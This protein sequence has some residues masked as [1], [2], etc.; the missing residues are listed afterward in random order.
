MNMNDL[1]AAL[2]T[3][4]SPGVMEELQAFA[5]EEAR[6]LDS[7]AFEAWADLFAEDGVYWVPSEPGQ[8]SPEDT[9]SLFH[10]TRPL[11]KLR[12]LTALLHL[13]QPLARLYGRARHGLTALRV[14]GPRS[15][16]LPFPRSSTIWSL[17][18]RAPEKALE[19]ISNSLRREGVALLIGGDYDRWELEARGG[20]LGAARLFM[21]VEEHGN[22]KQ[23]FRFRRWPRFSTAGVVA[24]GVF[25]CLSIGAALD[26]C[27]LA[28]DI[29]ALASLGFLARML[30]E[31]ACAMTALQRALEHGFKDAP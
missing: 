4:L 2:G 12:A 1:S 9:L 20:T 31:S 18:W 15:L 23:L 26:Q 13:L 10:E 29:L 5:F 22:G 6:L 25:T 28:Y 30:Y 16:T 27:W 17:K 21:T 14:R 7:G 8:V 19:I 24:L 3:A 11:L